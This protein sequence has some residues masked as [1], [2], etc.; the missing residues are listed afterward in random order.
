MEDAI[1]ID[2]RWY[3]PATSSRADDR[4]RVLKSGDGFAVFSRHGEIGWVGFGEQGFYFLGTRHL[5]F[6]HLR[7]AER[8]PMLLNSTVRLDNSRLVVDHTT[9]DLFQN[10]HIWIPKGC[11]HLH[12]ELVIHESSLS[13]RLKVVNYHDRRHRFSLEYLF[14]AD[15]H[16]IFEVRG[17]QRARRGKQPDPV[18]ERKTV[19]LAYEGLDGITRRT[20][21]GFDQ[22]PDELSGDNAKFWVELAPGESFV[23]E[24]MISCLSGEAYFCSLNHSETITEKNRKVA[25]D[26]E[27]RALIWSDNEQFN[28][29]LNRSAADLQMLITETR[30]GPYP[31]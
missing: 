22:F 19:V 25:A 2:N 14:D 24:S 18:F 16:D 8:E 1:Q 23:L 30:Y 27:L 6:W 7:L 31:Y 17:V 5:S 20:R 26:R 13:E 4:T 11:L 29:W 15:F 28:D 12:R 10:G 3:I 21:I 9:P